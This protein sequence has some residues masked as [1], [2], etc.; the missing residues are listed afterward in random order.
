M[1]M[2]EAIGGCFD[3]CFLFRVSRTVTVIEGSTLPLSC[4]GPR[5]TSLSISL[6]AASLCLASSA[7]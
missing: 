1:M 2:V 7:C 4:S 6:K 5:F 3:G